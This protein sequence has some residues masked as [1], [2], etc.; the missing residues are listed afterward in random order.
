L[1][2]FAPW[3]ASESTLPRQLRI[4]CEGAIYRVLS[5]DQNGGQLAS[6][7]GLWAS[8]TVAYT[9]ANRL[10]QTL[11]LQPPNAAAWTQNYGYDAVNRLQTISSPAGLFQYGYDGGLS[12]ASSSALVDNIN[13]PNGSIINNSY[14]SNARMTATLLLC[15]ADYTVADGSSYTYN[16]GNQ[17]TVMERADKHSAEANHVNYSYDKIGEVVAD[18]AYEG[19]GSTTRLNEQL[20]Y[21]FDPAGN[22]LYRTNNA[23]VANFQVNNLNELTAG[24]NGGTLT[25]MGTATSTNSGVTVNGTAAST[26]SDGTFAV[27]NMPLT[28]TYTAVA[29]DGYGRWATNVATVSLSS[30]ILY[31][32]DLN[33]NLTND[34]LRNF[35]Y[36]DENQLIQVS[37]PGQWLSQFQYDGKMRRRI[38]TEYSWQGSWVQTNKVYYVYDGNLV[39]QERDLNNLPTVTYT[40]GKDLSGSLESAGGIGGLLARTSQAYADASMGGNSFYHSDGNGN[41]TMLINSSNAVVAK[42]LY[43]AFGNTLSKSGLLADANLYRFS[44]KEWHPNS[45]LAYYLYR[46]YDPNLQ[47]WPNRD[48]IDS[49]T[50]IRLPTVFSDPLAWAGRVYHIPAELLSG[51]GPDLYT[52]MGNDPVDFIDMV[53]L[54]FMPPKG[55]N[56]NPPCQGPPGGVAAPQDGICSFPGGTLVAPWFTAC[57]AAHDACYTANGC[58]AFSWIPGCGS[59]ACKQC[60]ANVVSCVMNGDPHRKPP[61]FP[62]K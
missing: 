12:G 11:S 52:A 15:G 5:S 25:V 51:G 7:T 28:T 14:D 18:Q 33:G 56:K 29:H 40:R 21:V 1:A 30:N 53:G 48:P 47:R 10:R 61:L 3:W 38:R 44:S 50:L 6:E 41:I 57:C 17:R 34:G 49:P 16:V 55:C 24:T 32:Y 9:Y 8:D 36:D 2:C 13:L 37:V 19:G 4:E 20:G 46:F 43:D 45:G 31:Q 22:L 23:A 62:G 54:V 58:N 59:P 35:A 27:A 26:Y 42:Y 60:N 39:I